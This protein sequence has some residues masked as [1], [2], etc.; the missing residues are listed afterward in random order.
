MTH[1]L[2]G[3]D[4]RGY[5]ARLN[6]H[7][8][9]WAHGDAATRCFA[10]PAAHAHAD[11][12]SSTSVNLTD[13]SWCCHGC[14]ARGGAFDAAT[15]QGHTSR[16]A[17]DLM[18]EYGLT[19]RRTTTT[20]RARRQNSPTA[21]D[22]RMTGRADARPVAQL[23]ISEAQ[24]RRW[25]QHLLTARPTQKHLKVTRGWSEP[26][27]RELHLGLDRGRITIPVRDEHQALVALLRYQPAH[28][29]QMRAAVGSRRTLYPHPDTEPS[30][31][32]LLVEGEPDAI[33]ARSRGLPAIAIP[34]VE[35]WKQA[36]APLL[37]G[38]DV[39]IILDADP[40]GRACA[41]TVAQ[42]LADHARHVTTIDLAAEREDGYDLTDWLLDHPGHAHTHLAALTRRP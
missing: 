4:I 27:I 7:L 19:H 31:E 34:G 14:G 10:D 25:H 26:A 5:Y 6:I 17:I 22:R 3:A 1:T 21:R 39:T 41:H 32:I 15:H 24:V 8:P 18:I 23:N 38:R 35:S 30:S 40:P 20:T 11:Q 9:G 28:H 2:Q 16:S 33:A 12:S 29:G 13:G 37:S 36:W 42:H